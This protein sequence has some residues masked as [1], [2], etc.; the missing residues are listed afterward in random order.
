MAF[1]Q[2][3]RLVGKAREARPAEF[4][5]HAPREMQRQ[6]FDI[7]AA[8]AQGRQSDDLERQPVEQI[9]TKAAARHQAGQIFVGGA[10]QPHIDGDGAVG[11]DA[12]QFAIF[13]DAQQA[14]L[15]RR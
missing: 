3:H 1:E 15:R 9:G 11:A 2:R 4:G 10:D 14:F 8:F 6:H 12:G 13:D 7:L 5:R